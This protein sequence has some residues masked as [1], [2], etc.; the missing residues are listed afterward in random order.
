[1]VPRRGAAEVLQ[2]IELGAPAVVEGD[3]PA[4]RP[5]NTSTTY[6]NFLLR[7]FLRREKRAT[8]PPDLTAIIRYPSSLI[9]QTHCGPFGNLAVARHSI[10]SMNAASRWGRERSFAPRDRVIGLV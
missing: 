7:D 4:G 10:G 9:S 6:G 1:V 2:D 8:A 3:E 5:A